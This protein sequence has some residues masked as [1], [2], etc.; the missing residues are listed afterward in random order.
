MTEQEKKYREVQEKHVRL[1]TIHEGYVSVLANGI[2]KAEPS[3][4]EKLDLPSHEL[5][6]EGFMPEYYKEEPS[7]KAFQEQ[8]FA[9]NKLV[10]QWN[11][12]VDEN[13]QEMSNCLS[14]LQQTYG[15]K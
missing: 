15:V 9:Y 7:Q 1:R 2:S 5:T 14:T 10:D 12:A 11:A 6:L 8:R 4:L 3:I 13:Y